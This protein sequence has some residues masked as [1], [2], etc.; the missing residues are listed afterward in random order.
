[1]Y[2]IPNYRKSTITRATTTEGETIETKV[3]RI[4]SNKEP[5]K[6][7]APEIFTERKEGVVSAYNIRTDRWEIAADAMD[8]I[9]RSEQAKRDER[10]KAAEPKV[11]DMKGKEIGGAE[12]TQGTGGN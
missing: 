7:G 4:M 12:P 2:K 3:E 11:V 5:I 9:A 10:L 1:M 8:Y 6:D